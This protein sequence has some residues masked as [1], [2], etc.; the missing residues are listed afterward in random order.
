MWDFSGHGLYLLF[1]HS[2]TAEGPACRALGP[3]KLVRFEAR[4]IWAYGPLGEAPLRVATPA[5]SGPYWEIDGLDAVRW[6]DVTVLAPDRPTT[7]R[8]IESSNEWVRAG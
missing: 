1:Q 2:P 6:A 7:A 5:P 4:G 8:E 3:Y